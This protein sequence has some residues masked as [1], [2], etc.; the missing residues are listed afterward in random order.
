MEPYR[1]GVAAATRVPVSAVSLTC[2]EQLAPAA[3]QQPARCRALLQAPAGSALVVT[4]VI[5]GGWQRGKAGQLFGRAAGSCH[6]H[7][8]GWLSHSRILL[9]SLH[10]RRAPRVVL[11][12][13]QA[14][15]CPYL[16]TCLNA[17]R[18][19]YTTQPEAGAG[20]QAVSRSDAILQVP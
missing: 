9:P 10:L 13:A 2:S 3:Q 11:Q 6:W 12:S 1:R 5:S 17:V 20:A 8:S 19:D 15:R 16:P 4:L 7:W 14:A 18:I